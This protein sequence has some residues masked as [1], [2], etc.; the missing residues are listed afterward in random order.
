[1]VYRKRNRNGY[2]CCGTLS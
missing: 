1:M 2:F